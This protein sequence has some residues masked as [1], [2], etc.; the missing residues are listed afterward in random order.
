MLLP[1]A[2]LDKTCYL[3]E[4]CICW[5]VL[6]TDIYNMISFGIVIVLE[7]VISLGAGVKANLTFPSE[8]L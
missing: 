4:V 6:P 1:W 3:G 5:A 7:K 2:V 8:P